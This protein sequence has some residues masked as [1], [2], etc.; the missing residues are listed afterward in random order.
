MKQCVCVLESECGYSNLFLYRLFYMVLRARNY[1]D[2]IEICLT[3]RTLFKIRVFRVGHF[4]STNI[5]IA[6]ARECKLA[7]LMEIF[8]NKL[9]AHE[10]ASFITTIQEHSKGCTNSI[11]THDW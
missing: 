6:Q 4:A 2:L 9:V 10:K 3:K 1:P 8:Q 7:M 11:L 5:I